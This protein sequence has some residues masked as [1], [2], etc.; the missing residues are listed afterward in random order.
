MNNKE[1]VANQAGDCPNELA[2]APAGEN[3]SENTKDESGG[4][5]AAPCSA[6]FGDIWNTIAPTIEK[7][8]EVGWPQPYTGDLLTKTQK[9]VQEATSDSGTPIKTAD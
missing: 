4:L 5:P 6:P 8:K 1:S 3:L 2:L 9:A 7:M